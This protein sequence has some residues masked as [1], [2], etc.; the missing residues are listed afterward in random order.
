MIEEGTEGIE[1]KSIEEGSVS[2]NAHRAL[3]GGLL[4]ELLELRRDIAVIKADLTRRAEILVKFGNQLRSNP[5]VIEID[6]QVLEPNMR[7]AHKS[8]VRRT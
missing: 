5:Q 1:G 7:R 6:E 3:A 8:S 4:L 2:H